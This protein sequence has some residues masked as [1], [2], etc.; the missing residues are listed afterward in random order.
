MPAHVVL[1]MGKRIT[2]DPDLLNT[3]RPAE[4]RSLSLLEVDFKHT[5][6]FHVTIRRGDKFRVE[7]KI[8]MRYDDDWAPEYQLGTY[9]VYRDD[10]INKRIELS[11]IDPEK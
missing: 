6:I 2:S 8:D 10:Y 7:A 9:N 11:T 4:G 1:R 3:F 5:E